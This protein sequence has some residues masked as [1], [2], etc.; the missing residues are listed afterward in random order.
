VESRW[1]RR[2]LDPLRECLWAASVRARLP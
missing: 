2:L 1:E